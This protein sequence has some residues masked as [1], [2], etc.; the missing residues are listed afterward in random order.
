MEKGNKVKEN[1]SSSPSPLQNGEGE[2]SLV[3]MGVRIK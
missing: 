2:V 1:Y 3:L